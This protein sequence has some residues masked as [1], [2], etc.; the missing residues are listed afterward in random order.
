[1]LPIHDPDRSRRL[2]REL[3]DS[4]ELTRRLREARSD[5]ATRIE[6]ELPAAEVVELPIAEDVCVLCELEGEPSSA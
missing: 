1:M 4:A 3:R 5:G 2:E 6:P